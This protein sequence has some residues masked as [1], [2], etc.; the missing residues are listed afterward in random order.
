LEEYNEYKALV[1]QKE[2]T[3]KIISDKDL[4]DSIYSNKSNI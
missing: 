3:E 2:K 1:E 4:F